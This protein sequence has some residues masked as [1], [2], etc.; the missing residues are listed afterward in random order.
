MLVP[1]GDVDA[2]AAMIESVATSPADTIDRW[3]SALRQPRTM[4]DVTKD[5]LELY[6]SVAVEV[7]PK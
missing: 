2:L 1:A 5:Y 7:A 6:N 3:R 4:D